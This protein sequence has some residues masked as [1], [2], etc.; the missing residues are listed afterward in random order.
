M[1]DVSGAAM[2][3]ETGETGDPCLCGCLGWPVRAGSRPYNDQPPNT[4]VRD[5]NEAGQRRSKTQQVW[6]RVMAHLLSI[7]HSRASG[8]WRSPDLVADTPTKGAGRPNQ[9]DASER[10]SGRRRP[11]SQPL[12]RQAG[13][14]RRSRWAARLDSQPASSAG[15][16]RGGTGLA[17]A[18]RPGPGGVEL[19]DGKDESEGEWCGA[20]LVEGLG[21]V[22][23]ALP[24][25]PAVVPS[26]AVA[27]KQR[28]LVSLRFVEVST[29]LP[30]PRLS[31]ALRGV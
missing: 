17:T 2:G 8:C 26:G 7:I 15:T 5:G 20:E 10:A 29:K 27:A 24:F 1:P 12:A 13:A 11:P 9:R 22:V 14:A 30:M 25:P 23:A 6:F 3:N 4:N 31:A 28:P 18:R 19:G 21:A 16:D